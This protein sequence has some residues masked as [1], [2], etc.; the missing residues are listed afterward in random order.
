MAEYFNKLAEEVQLATEELRTIF[1]DLGAASSSGGS[2]KKTFEP[3]GDSGSYAHQFDLDDLSFDG[4]TEEEIQQVLAEE[5]L[6]NN[7]LQ[8]IAEG[9]TK[10]ILAGQVRSVRGVVSYRVESSRFQNKSNQNKT[11]AAIQ[12]KTNGIQVFRC[13][14]CCHQV[15]GHSHEG[16]NSFALL[17]SNSLVFFIVFTRTS[18]S[19][20]FWGKLILQRKK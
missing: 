13:V 17:L 2:S 19:L 5:L 3:S 12:A 11:N 20:F 1:S 16:T 4:M 15:I 7:P 8:G 18:F 6:Q 10:D 14:V 9:V